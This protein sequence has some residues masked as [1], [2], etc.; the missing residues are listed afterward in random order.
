MNKHK[1]LVCDLDGTLIKT[2]ILL[3]SIL[4]LIRNKPLFLF[5]LPI[6]LLS[7]RSKFKSQ[8]FSHTNIKVELLP[9]N[10][11][12]INFLKNEKAKGRKLILATAS[13]SEIAIQVSDYLGI[14]DQVFGSNDK[15][16]LK[17]TNKANLLIEKF[18]DKNFD[19]IGDSK[20][21]INVWKASNKA[22]YV[23]SNNNLKNI[24]KSNGDYQI[25][26][27]EKNKIID[28]IK[29]IR[30]YQWVKNILIFLPA[31]MAH[32]VFV[33]NNLLNS[34]FAF[35]SLSFTASF[36]YLINDMI[37]LESDREHPRKKNRPFASGKLDLMFGVKLSIILII[38]GLLISFFA[39]GAKFT[40][41]LLIYFAITTLYSFYLKK[42]AILDIMILASLYTIRIIAG[43][44]ASNTPLSPWLLGF[45]MFIFLS[46]AIVKR[47]TELLSLK[48][49]NKLKVAGRGYYIEDMNL[50]VSIG[51]AAGYL[52]VLVFTLYINSPDIK[53][54]YHHS[55][56]LWL[57][58]PM[59]IFWITRIWLLANRGQMTDDPIVFAVKDKVSIIVALISVILVI[60]ASI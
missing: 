5:I 14:F 1:I 56:Y 26:E 45:S 34:L 42:I 33:D 46:L 13:F 57:I 47:Y 11:D 20:A 39:V 44:Y 27:F 58:A 17:S 53:L 23:G 32:K 48:S 59:L 6:W 2:D 28:I 10:Q 3:E 60:F 15:I 29:E 49:E 37:D 12:V 40:E 51:P 8:I 30:I 43:G 7:S 19:Y 38:S 52:A 22:I 21:D 9:Y 16:N 35:F 18:G 55:K 36:V 31:L 50:L 25:I 54:L 4:I 24:V 41:I